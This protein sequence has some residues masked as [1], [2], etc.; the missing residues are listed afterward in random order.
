MK[1]KRILFLLSF[2]LSLA[3]ALQPHKNNAKTSVVFNAD[4]ERFRK[5]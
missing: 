1:N 4:R 5:V 3:I 2:C